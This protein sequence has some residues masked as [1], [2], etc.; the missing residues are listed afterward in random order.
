MKNR[1]VVLALTSLLMLATAGCG[2][3]ATEVQIGAILSMGGRASPYGQSIWQGMQVAMDE[4]NAAGGIDVG[5]SG[6]MLPLTIEMR[7]DQSDPQVALRHARE[8]IELQ[9]PVV[10]AADSS[11]V[12]LA[13]A[14]LFQEAEIIFMSPSASTP[15]LSEEGDYIYRNFPSDALEAV[16]MATHIYNAAGIH[17][18]AILGSQSE[19]GLGVKNA[20][21]SRFRMLGGAVTAQASFEAE[22]PDVSGQVAELSDADFGGIY[23][24][25]YSSEVAIVAQAVR[26]AGIEVP[27]FGTGAVLAEELVELGGDAVE[28][29]V[30]P[31]P[32]FDPASEIEESRRF[33]AAYEAR[34]G[35]S[36]DVYAA[37]GWDAVKIIVQAIQENG[38]RPE[39]IRFYL[40]A[41]NPFEGAAGTT[42]FDDKGDVRKF[43]RMFV[44]QGGQAVPVGAEGGA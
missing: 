6:T 36:Y 33:V 41:M 27:L 21:I 20:F 25:G 1:H 8:L 10:I 31:S 29:L 42:S 28:G 24:A 12:A 7:D 40:N 9:L 35:D 44:I 17:E 26:A 43:H 39:E 38:L 34:F 32:L 5:G 16:N 23:V 19:Y 14:P 22:A 2:S 4:V 3:S 15:K 13:I 18:V 37:H 30:F 11:E